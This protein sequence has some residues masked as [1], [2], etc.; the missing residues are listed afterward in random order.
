[1]SKKTTG[2]E[3][4]LHAFFPLLDCELGTHVKV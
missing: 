3:S 4:G 2:H 1:M